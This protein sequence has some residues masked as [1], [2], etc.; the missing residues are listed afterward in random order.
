[1]ARRRGAAGVRVA[2]EGRHGH[3]HQSS[4][5]DGPRRAHRTEGVKQDWWIIQEIARRIGLDWNYGGPA[6]VFAEMKGCM[7]S[8]D[9]ISWERLRREGGVTYPCEARKS[10]AA[11]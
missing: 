9:N 4:G 10:P 6:D 5:P 11:T 3:Q 1:M 2:G 7:P 8:L